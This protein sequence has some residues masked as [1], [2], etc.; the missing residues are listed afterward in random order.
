[1]LVVLIDLAPSE[2]RAPEE[3]ER[4]LLDE[5]GRYQPELLDR[6]RIVVGS[7]ADVADADV[8]WQGPRMT[9]DHRRRRARARR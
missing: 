5:L 2:G 1:M 8:Q 3:Q 9:C 6:P 7:R 4:V